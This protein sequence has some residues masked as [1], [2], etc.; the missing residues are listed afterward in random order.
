M[1]ASLC[2]LSLLLLLGQAEPAVK[3]EEVKKLQGTWVLMGMETNGA[4]IEGIDQ[5][6]CKLK[7]KGADFTMTQGLGKLEGILQLDV[8]KAPA[9]MDTE[10]RDAQ[11]NVQRSYGIYKI[12]G[13][14]LTVCF[15]ADKALRPLEFKT[16]KGTDLVLEVFKRDKN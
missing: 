5:L 10:A 7:V 6:R 13:D 11:G 8:A 14:T 3:Q 15:S 16:R 1:L 9:Q 4:K 12:E 2:L